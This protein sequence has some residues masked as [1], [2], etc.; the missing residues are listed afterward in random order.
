MATA[1][2]KWARASPAIGLPSLLGLWGTAAPRWS[3]GGAA[4]SA[5]RGKPEWDQRGS[6]EPGRELEEK[7][8]RNGG[9]HFQD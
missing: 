4:S 7:T 8:Q 9:K 6:A 3:Q 1:A 2:C 5:Q